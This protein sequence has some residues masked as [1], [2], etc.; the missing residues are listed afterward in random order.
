VLAH[1]PKQRRVI[2]DIHARRLAVDR[3]SNSHLRFLPLEFV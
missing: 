3:E 1:H 2:V